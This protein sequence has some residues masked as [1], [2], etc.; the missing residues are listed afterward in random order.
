MGQ[1]YIIAN[2]DR[3]EFIEPHTFCDGAELLEFGD[4]AGGTMCG[5]AILLADG[6]G[7]GG[8]DLMTE[9]KVAGSW[10][11]DRIVIAGDYADPDNFMSDDLKKET[12][13]WFLNYHITHNTNKEDAEKYAR[14]N[15]TIYHACHCG[16][17][18]DIS[19]DVIRTMADD[20]DLKANLREKYNNDYQLRKIKAATRRKLGLTGKAK[21]TR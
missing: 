6:N 20:P 4:S 17:L 1:Y 15:T 21:D 8:G 18:K 3:R 14:S 19:D 2:I 10:K 16:L 12:Y 9:S 7:R 11:G 13:E 5:L